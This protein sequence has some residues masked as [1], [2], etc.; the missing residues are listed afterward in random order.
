MKLTKMTKSQITKAQKTVE[1]LIRDSDEPISIIEFNW[2]GT[3]V[4]NDGVWKPNRFSPNDRSE[5]SFSGRVRLQL[6]KAK[7]WKWISGDRHGGIQV[8]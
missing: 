1:Q 8:K 7:M 5:D 6:G 4:S 2:E 3:P